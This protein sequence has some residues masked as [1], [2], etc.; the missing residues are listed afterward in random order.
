MEPVIREA[1]DEDGWA[2]CIGLVRDRVVAWRDGLAELLE[3]ESPLLRQLTSRREPHAW[4]GYGRVLNPIVVHHGAAS[5]VPGVARTLREV[6]AHRALLEAVGAWLGPPALTQATWVHSTRGTALHCD[7]HPMEPGAPI[8]GAW[9]ALED[10]QA[11]AGPFVVVPGS[12]ELEGGDVRAWRTAAERASAAQ[13]R[14]KTDPSGRAGVEAARRLEQVLAAR[15]L[16]A[17]PITLSAGDVLL[18]RGDLVHGS[19]R[20]RPAGGTRQSLLLHF[21][22][23]RFAR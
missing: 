3:V 6:L 12:L 20:P 14:A 2:V 10:I 5:T 17:R 21:V 11:S 18:W 22:E 7:P 13:F 1:L 19:Q 16:E 15:R 9:V 4:D 8:L 23:R